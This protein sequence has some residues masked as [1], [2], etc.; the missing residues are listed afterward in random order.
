MFD[1]QVALNIKYVAGVNQY[2]ETMNILFK[3]YSLKTTLMTRFCKQIF[4]KIICCEST[5]SSLQNFVKKLIANPS[6]C[7]LNNMKSVFYEYFILI[8]QLES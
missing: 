5:S 3:T 2:F 8:L 4:S 6:K 1:I 7:S